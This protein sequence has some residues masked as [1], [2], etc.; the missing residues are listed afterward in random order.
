MV[1]IVVDMVTNQKCRART[2]ERE[3]EREMEGGG[4]SEVQGGKANQAGERR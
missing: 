1:T 2:S 3:R 4:G